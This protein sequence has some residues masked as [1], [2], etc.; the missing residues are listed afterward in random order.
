MGDD[1]QDVMGEE[2]ESAVDA[3]EA[4]GDSS[5]S[6]I[7]KILLYVAGG[8]LLIVL[9]IGISY[10]VAKNVQ[11]SS[12]EK[13]QDIVSAP[14]PP[15][16]HTYELTPEFAK[17]TADE[18][19]HFIKMKVSFGYKHSV[20]LNSELVQRKDQ[21]RHIINI[22]LQGKKF[23]DLDS[24]TDTVA[25]TEE[26]KAHVNVILVKGKIKEVYLLEFVVN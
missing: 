10:L 20:E 2:E 25:L 6:K 19:P 24:V 14:P 8:I 23:E 18:E 26:I 16:L 4:S 5:T 21:I 11:E 12:Y 17:T 7:V 22:I 13:S 3:E 1:E 15:P 9:V